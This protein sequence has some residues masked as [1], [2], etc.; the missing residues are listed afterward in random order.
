MVENLDDEDTLEKNAG[1][2]TDSRMRR[3]AE[4]PEIPEEDKTKYQT[5]LDN[6]YD[7]VSQV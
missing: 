6:L 4:I 2:K 7:N 5:T 3:Q 1:N